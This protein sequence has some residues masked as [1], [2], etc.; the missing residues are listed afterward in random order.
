MVASF[1][2]S[3]EHIMHG[4]VEPWCLLMI[5]ASGIA[6]G[7][8]YFSPKH[9]GK[10]Q[11]FEPLLC[12][13][14]LRNKSY[15]VLFHARIVHVWFSSAFERYVDDGGVLPSDHHMLAGLVA[16]RGLLVIELMDID[17]LGP[18][19]SYGCMLGAEDLQG[20]WGD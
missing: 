8:Q 10:R 20:G 5:H 7:D 17:W 3:I 19:S 4:E 14:V 11:C 16:P 18:W 12:Q 13:L 6:F 2:R 15:E 1:E 9:N